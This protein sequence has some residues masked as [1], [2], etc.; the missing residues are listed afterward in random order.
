MEPSSFPL[1]K[2]LLL[3]HVTF[4]KCW[5]CFIN[6]NVIP[7]Q[8][9]HCRLES[10]LAMYGRLLFQVH[11][12]TPEHTPLYRYS[13]S[14]ALTDG[15][16]PST[17][18]FL[19]LTEASCQSLACRNEMLYSDRLNKRLRSMNLRGNA[20]ERVAGWKKLFG[21]REPC[22]LQLTCMD[23]H[24]IWSGILTVGS[25]RRKRPGPIPPG[26]LLSKIKNKIKYILK[27]FSRCSKIQ[28]QG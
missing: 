17:A 21:Y 26:R 11:V 14:L 13:Y 22:H 19:R 12:H 8:S 5:S 15:L 3:D 6:A 25:W 27:I 20:W 1:N 18:A 2:G 4:L 24:G 10:R 23:S 7:P 9:K 16:Y 28:Y